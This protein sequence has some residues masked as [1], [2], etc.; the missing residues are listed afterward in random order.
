MLRIKALAGAIEFTDKY[1]LIAM[2]IQ[3]YIQKYKMTLIIYIY[4]K[5]SGNKVI[6]RKH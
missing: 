6:P 3:M 5:K 2:I 1:Q 4:L